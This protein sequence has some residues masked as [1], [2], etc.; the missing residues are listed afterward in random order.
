MQINY[1]FVSVYI[2]ELPIKFC[3]HLYT[4]V[5]I[6]RKYAPFFLFL[7]SNVAFVAAGRRNNNKFSWQCAR[8]SSKWRGMMMDVQKPAVIKFLVT[9]K[10][11]VTNITGSDFHLFV[12]QNRFHPCEKF[13]V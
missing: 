3:N 8:K 2:R 12:A 6:N 11:G 10:E 5:Q 9:E 4:S 7:I 1:Y 13:C